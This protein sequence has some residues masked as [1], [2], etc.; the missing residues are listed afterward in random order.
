MPVGENW[1]HLWSLSG[2]RDNRL[3]NIGLEASFLGYR[4]TG[5]VVA[6]MVETVFYRSLFRVTVAQVL[7]MGRFG[8]ASVIVLLALG[9]LIGESG[10]CCRGSYNDSP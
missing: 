1:C 9:A 5:F 3:S 8:T 7:M 2:R 6:R 4:G 10:G